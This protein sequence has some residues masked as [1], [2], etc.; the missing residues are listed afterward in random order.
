MYNLS[1]RKYLL[2]SQSPKS[3]NIIKLNKGEKNYDN[4]K[5]CEG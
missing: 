3:K 2:V 4:L 1:F 5:P